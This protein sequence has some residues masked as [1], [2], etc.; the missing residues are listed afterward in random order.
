MRFTTKNNQPKL[1][2]IIMMNYEKNK[3]TNAIIVNG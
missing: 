1:Q 3:I 2:R